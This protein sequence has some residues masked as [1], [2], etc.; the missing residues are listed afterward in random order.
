MDN[1]DKLDKQF[2]KAAGISEE[3]KDFPALDKV[4]A[5]V[6]EKLDKKEDKKVIA[7]WKKIGVAASLLLFF[8]LGYQ[9]LKPEPHPIVPENSIVLEN[10]LPTEKATPEATPAVSTSK[11]KILPQPEVEKIIKKQLQKEVV[12]MS[13]ETEPQKE[14]AYPNYAPVMLEKATAV[15]EENT[16]A[17][18]TLSK[19]TA[20]APTLMSRSTVTQDVVVK[21][22]STNEITGIQT[23][24]GTVTEEGLPLPGVSI[25]VIQAKRGTETDVN[26]NFTLQAQVGERVQFS[27]P[28]MKTTML[29]VGENKQIDV[30]LQADDQNLQE[31]VVTGYQK[32][33]RKTRKL[34]KARMEAMATPKRSNSA[35][36]YVSITRA[37]QVKNDGTPAIVTALAGNIA[38][39]NI[40]ADT[41]QSV[42]TRVLRAAGSQR[43]NQPLYIIDGV[44]ISRRNLKKMNPEVIE[45][46]TTIKSSEAE[47]HYGTN[48]RNGAIILTSK[49]AV[50]RN[51][52]N[53]EIRRKLR[54][55][56][57][58]SPVSPL[59]AVENSEEEYDSFVENPFENPKNNPL[60]TFS[61]DVD[62]ASYTN[63]RRFINNG[64]PVPK[65][66]VRVEEMIN[67]FK[68]NYAQPT[69]I[70][71]FSITTEY[72][73][74]P[75]NTQHQIVRIGLQGK[76]IP[77]NELPASNF[78][79][80][81]DVSG[82]MED[83]NKLPLLKA[84]MK[85]LVDQLR[86]E[87]TVAII[88]YA[89]AAGMVLPP[90][91]G[92]AKQTIMAALDKL[93][94]GGSTAGGAGIELAYKTAA[95]HF[96][97]SG[98]N[99]VIL[100]TDGDF[101]VGSSSDKDMQSLIEEK[102]KSGIFLTCLGFGMGNYKDR[103]MELLSDKGNGN[104]AYI[105]NM[106]EA[107]R[108][109]GKEFKGSMFAIAKDVKIQIEFNPKHVQSYRL[110]GY[111]NRKLRNEDFTDDAIDAGELGS[112]HTVTALYEII[113][114]GS[115]SPFG[116]SELPLK[117]TDTKATATHTD[118]LA[119]IKFR[120]KKPD[121]NKS[122]EIV[123]II[124]NQSVPLQAASE[125]FRFST[126]VA[127][128]GLKLRNSEYVPNK[129]QQAIV[130]LARKA[131]SHDPDGYKAEFIR[132]V[133]T[134][135]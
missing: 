73:V 61:I 79:F 19:K 5:R 84:S 100:A 89:G 116:S 60:S 113:P 66:A 99:R 92:A 50:F 82:S 111:E 85:V 32:A 47:A 22:I 59:S 27:Y 131:Q 126:A 28:G 97:K 58:E 70:H 108:F 55:L 33:D 94:A 44:I 20:A 117:Y 110:I 118:E 15:V 78:V 56:K 71:P 48:G 133:E 104:Y 72:S 9:F 39:L 103:K 24:K 23:L 12:V 34:A 90:T 17:N 40:T 96:I 120:Y 38:G 68:Y 105:D 114:T 63:I 49:N 35:A 1:H 75:W 69:G 87:D 54:Q 52:T 128:F 25:A 125:D 109:L 14:A 31:V 135:E 41:V 13:E 30:A 18:A 26:G 36:G 67:F 42:S 65:D 16:T 93:N 8:S 45:T 53:R 43:Q 37:K 101:N 83:E 10:D 119:T 124:E 29:T 62:N 91:S 95:E 130:A 98:N 77:T 21:E 7:L 107:N 64:Q 115:N 121:G 129:S 3:N 127:W 86:K 57:K 74:A 123:Q 88:V 2:Q 80:L 102:R 51:M 122:T 6:E 112:G 81:I 4:W 132:L 134:I 76:I 106:Q 11:T 46:I